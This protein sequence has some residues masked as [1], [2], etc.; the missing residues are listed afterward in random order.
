MKE[1]SLQF[2]HH[3]SIPTTIINRTGRDIRYSM[4][5]VMLLINNAIRTNIIY[6]LRDLYD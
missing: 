4:G 3:T 5:D 2:Q 6:N 1:I